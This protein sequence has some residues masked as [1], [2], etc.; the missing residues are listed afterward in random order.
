MDD[1]HL[2][3]QYMLVGIPLIGGLTG[4]VGTIACHGY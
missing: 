4:V 1:C 3:P 2:F